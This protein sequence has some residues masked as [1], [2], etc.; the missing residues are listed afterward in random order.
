MKWA[1][2]HTARINVRHRTI[3]IETI[4][5][6]HTMTVRET[7]EFAGKLLFS[8]YLLALVCTIGPTRWFK[9]QGG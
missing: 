9:T 8:A 3:A 4:A 1:R 7:L 2:C 5:E 6:E